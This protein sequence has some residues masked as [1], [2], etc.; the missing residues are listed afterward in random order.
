MAAGTATLDFGA[1]PGKSWAALAVTG[2]ATLAAGDHVECWVQGSDSTADHSDGEH[3]VIAM[4]SAAYA[5]D[6]VA[7]TGFTVELQSQ[8]VLTGTVKVRW[9]WASAA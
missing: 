2:Q 9:V 8:L 3:Q 5:R 7:G 6:I 4:H 1:A